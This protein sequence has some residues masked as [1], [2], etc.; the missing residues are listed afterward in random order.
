[1]PWEPLG[2]T[3]RALSQGFQ[4]PLN[5]T[6]GTQSHQA[7]LL[8]HS[9]TTMACGRQGLQQTLAEAWAWQQ[10]SQEDSSSAMKDPPWQQGSIRS[11]IARMGK[12]KGKGSN[13][14]IKN[15]FTGIA[16]NCPLTLLSLG[17]CG[18]N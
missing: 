11:S 10:C 18:T 13:R 4:Q 17:I 8:P 14:L 6:H 12:E 2:M 15:I 9:S 1:M 7:V 16:V 3:E 5:A